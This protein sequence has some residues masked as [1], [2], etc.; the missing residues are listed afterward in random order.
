MCWS[1]WR[2]LLGSSS[3]YMFQ[4]SGRRALRISASS[5]IFALCAATAI[6]QRHPFSV[7]GFFTYNGLPVEFHIILKNNESALSRLLNLRCG[8]LNKLRLNCPIP[9]GVKS[10]ENE[11]TGTHSYARIHAQKHAA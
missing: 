5:Q 10:N 2:C 7:D 11:R 6:R 1:G 4:L 3:A 8:Y 9:F